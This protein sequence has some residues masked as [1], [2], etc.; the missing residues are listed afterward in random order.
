MALVLIRA[1]RKDYCAAKR[2]ITEVHPYIVVYSSSLSQKSYHSSLALVLN[3]FLMFRFFILHTLNMLVIGGTRSFDHFVGVQEDIKL[4]VS[5][6]SAL[7]IN[8]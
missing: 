7:A 8:H 5:A 1:S 3:T 4:S 6:F 2:T